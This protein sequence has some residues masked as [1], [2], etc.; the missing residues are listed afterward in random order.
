MVKIFEIL[1][2]DAA[3]NNFNKFNM[4]EKRVLMLI[5]IRMYNITS[6]NDV[7]D[8]LINNFKQC[9]TY[10]CNELDAITPSARNFLSSDE[11]EKLF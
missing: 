5:I 2:N 4:T 3:K 11:L 8:L 10:I 9:I 1:L 7:N 6:L